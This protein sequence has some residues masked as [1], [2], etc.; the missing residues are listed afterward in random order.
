MRKSIV[1]LFLSVLLCCFLA[2]CAGLLKSEEMD[3]EAERILEAL[4]EDDADQIFQSMYPGVVTRE[5]FDASYE[6][7]RQLWKKSDEY[8]MKLRAINTNKNYNQSG[9]SLVRQAQ[10]YVYTP[11]QDYTITLTYRSDDI[12]EGIY[13]FNLNIGAEPVLVSG[14]FTTAS[15][16]SVLQWGL[17]ILSVL[18]YLFVLATVVD[19]LRKRP[20]LFGVWI[21]AA[22]TFA[23][24]LIQAAPSNFHLGLRVIWFA[25]SAFKIYSNGIRNFVF[26]LPVGAIVYWC[27]RKKLLDKKMQAM[28]GITPA[29]KR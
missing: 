12:G 5:E 23:G 19:I 14:G 11:D 17:L 29:K 16:N 24:F 18:S 20:R 22:L 7:V 6:S 8:T 3:R 25:L 13:Q 1:V 15:Q 9:N 2:G 21:A 27:M 26:V 10:Y 4:N 28:Q